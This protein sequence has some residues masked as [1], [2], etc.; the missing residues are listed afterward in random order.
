[1]EWGTA[2]T[3]SGSMQR[4][5]S[6]PIASHSK[7]QVSSCWG[8]RMTHCIFSEWWGFLSVGKNMV[9]PMFLVRKNPD[10]PGDDVDMEEVGVP[11][12]VAARES[13]SWWELS[14]KFPV[15]LWIPLLLLCP[16]LRRPC[17]QGIGRTAG[18]PVRWLNALTRPA[19]TYATPCHVVEY[20]APVPAVCAATVPVNELCGTVRWTATVYRRNTMPFRCTWV[21]SRYSASPP[22]RRVLIGCFVVR[23]TLLDFWKHFLFSDKE[24]P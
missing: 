14:T 19:V 13:S 4:T 2:T 6:E 11:L 8:P 22:Q 18:S 7:E 10:E 3:S 21:S 24:N 15:V 9:R 16:R 17:A 20:I 1:M 23:T 12:L 5:I